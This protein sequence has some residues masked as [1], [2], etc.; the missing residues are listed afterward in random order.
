MP[1]SIS[2][3][4]DEWPTNSGPGVTSV[5]P[6]FGQAGSDGCNVKDVFG[7]QNSDQMVIRYLCDHIRSEAHISILAPLI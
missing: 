7:L 2:G 5:Y 3:S 6:Q 4:E 1:K